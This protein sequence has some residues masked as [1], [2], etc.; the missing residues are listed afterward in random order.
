MSRNVVVDPAFRHVSGNQ[1]GF[2]VWRIE[3]MQVV[4]IPAEAWGKF[5]TGDSYIIFSSSPHGT[6]GGTGV[7]NGIHNGRV[8]QHLH[9]WLG[10][11]TQPMSLQLLLTSPLNLMNI[12]VGLQSSIEKFR[13]R[14]TKGSGHIYK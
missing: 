2:H 3:D 12:L 13:V 9:F 6:A 1:T 11:E 4:S 7:K 5:F 14:N 10:N 8:E